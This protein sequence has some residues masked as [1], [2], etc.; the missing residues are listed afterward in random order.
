MKYKG[1]FKVTILSVIGLF[2][3]QA[4]ASE[5][6]IP[7]TFQDGQVTS[8]SEMNANFEAIKAAVNDN[9]NR[10]DAPRSQFVGF[11]STKLDG[12]GGMF[13]MQQACHALV[14]ESHMCDSSEVTGSSYSASAMA[15]IEEGDSAWIRVKLA[16][17]ISDQGQ[18]IAED[19][20]ITLG[21]GTPSYS[22]QR[23]GSCE[24]WKSNAGGSYGPEGVIITHKGGLG[25]SKC[26]QPLKVACCR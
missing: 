16:G 23:V 26:D 13:A 21:N 17:G 24:G 4:Q 20:S 3:I 1:V 14:T 19:L 15:T 10:I 7:N 22:A 9:N 12:A 5:L 6:E 2:L 18:A 25:Q 8:A 11:S